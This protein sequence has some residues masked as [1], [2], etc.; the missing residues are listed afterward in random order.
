MFFHQSNGI[1]FLVVQR[2]GRSEVREK[3]TPRERERER[4][5][6]RERGRWTPQREE[7][8]QREWR[9]K[10]GPVIKN[11]KIGIYIKN[12]QDSSTPV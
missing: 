12:D 8:K 11:K 2:D 1:G 4:D 7:N 5:V 6:G 9:G 10:W 3:K